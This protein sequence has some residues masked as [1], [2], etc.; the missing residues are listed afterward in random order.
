LKIGYVVKRYPRYSE[1]FIV[2]EILAHEKAGADVRIFA[3][4]PS[5]DA[6]FQDTLSRV[7]APVTYLR[8]DNIRT[9][10]FW[11]Y[12]TSAAEEFSAAAKVLLPGA[13]ETP[14]EVCQGI[15]LAREARSAGIE[16]LHAHFATSAT[17]VARIASLI[18]GIP[19]TFTAHAK[20]IY[21]E[22]VDARGFERKL[23]DAAVCVTVSDYNVA[24][25]QQ[26]YGTAAAGV[27]RIYNG[28]ELADFPY[29][30][31]ADREA[32]IVGVGRLVEKKG[33]DDLVEACGL[34]ASR[35]ER[36]TCRLIG[37][38]PLEASLRRR[39]DDHGIAD[40]VMLSGPRP[41]A[42]VIK[43]V[44]SAAV[45]AAPSVIALDGDR[46]G[47]PTVMLE[48]MA[49]GTPSIGT[50]V[51]G[52]PEAIRDGETGLIVPAHD[53]PRLAA[54]LSALLNDSR[55]RV[56]LADAARRRIE[57]EFD[58]HRN[59]AS[60]RELFTRVRQTHELERI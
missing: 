38:G 53:P 21:H 46:D 36:F 14:F 48:A 35:G 3:L 41:Q 32:L 34:L 54:A 17:A 49:L 7:R 30:S 10:D 59:A 29:T 13:G 58:S 18:S 6:H 57:V 22:G 26:R 2:S 24:F 1:T 44:R 5:F 42:D 31:P 43:E 52:I 28:L 27:V 45:L 37:T 23:R 40:C 15:A 11:G 9:L 39:I 19:F 51:T 60:L 12:V 47:L 16:H 56:R 55:L 50:P 33:F 20:D 8:F 25:L 4:G